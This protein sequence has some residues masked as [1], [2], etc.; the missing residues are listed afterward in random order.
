MPDP[1]P[2]LA[3]ARQRLAAAGIPFPPVPEEAW[4]HLEALG[5][6]T[7]GLPG[8]LD[9]VYLFEHWKQALA[10][11]GA[12]DFLAF[13]RSG[14]GIASGAVH[15]YW[16]KGPLALL[17]QRGWGGIDSAAAAAPDRLLDTWDRVA[18]LLEVAAEADD[19]QGRL[20]VASSDLDL[21]STWAWTETDEPARWTSEPHDAIFEVA[22]SELEQAARV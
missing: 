7:W 19:V 10:A 6:L 17:V 3:L 22:A 15:F 5:A 9:D 13:G 21:W 1:S 18:S 2:V 8:A 11:G 12:G 4:P 14:H 20:A 16:A